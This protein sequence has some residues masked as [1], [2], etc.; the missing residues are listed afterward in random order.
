MTHFFWLFNEVVIWGVNFTIFGD[1]LIKYSIF[2][3][4]LGALEVV[5]VLEDKKYK[6][7]DTTKI[8]GYCNQER[9]F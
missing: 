4:Y 9:H 1:L 8:F 7:I 5:M 3:N 6:Y 2:L